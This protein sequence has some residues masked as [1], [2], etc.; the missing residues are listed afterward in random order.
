MT[1]RGTT[2]ESS[3]HHLVNQQS[4][5][6]PDAKQAFIQKNKASKKGRRIATQATR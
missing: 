5:Y 3:F 6:D 1:A 2:P 4:Q